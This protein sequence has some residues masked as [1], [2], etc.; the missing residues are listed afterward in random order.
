MLTPCFFSPALKHPLK[1]GIKRPPSPQPQPPALAHGVVSPSPPKPPL[2]LM[3][4][5]PLITITKPRG[6]FLTLLPNSTPSPIHRIRIQPL[7]PATAS[8][9]HHQKKPPRL[10]FRS[11]L[12]LLPKVASSISSTSPPA[13]SLPRAL[14]LLSPRVKSNRSKPPTSRKLASSKRSLTDVKSRSQ[15]SAMQSA[16]AKIAVRL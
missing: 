11:R 7:L 16:K 15:V 8:A 3:P 6:F 13:R 12:P 1:N 14:F 10:S 9:Q 2:E 5:A 4:R